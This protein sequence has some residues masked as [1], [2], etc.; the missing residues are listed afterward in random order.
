M[1]LCVVENCGWVGGWVVDTT[2][3]LV[4]DETMQKKRKEYKNELC[5]RFYSK[6]FH[7]HV[8]FF[9]IIGNVVNYKDYLKWTEIK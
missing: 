4:G 6:M 1:K 9:H 2:Q 3:L 8:E 7:R 5:S